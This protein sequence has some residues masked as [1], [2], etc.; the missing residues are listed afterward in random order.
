[1]KAEF[2]KSEDY[3]LGILPQLPSVIATLL[4]ANR[5]VKRRSDFALAEISPVDAEGA[6]LVHPQVVV[7]QPILGGNLVTWTLR[8]HQS[9]SSS[10]EVR[11]PPRRKFSIFQFVVLFQNHLTSTLQIF[12]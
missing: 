4:T 3:D 12:A 11:I 10:G 7:Q 6:L 2:E 1:M 5:G 9:P 8:K